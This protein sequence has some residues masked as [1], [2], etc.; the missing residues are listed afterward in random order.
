MV[1]PQHLLYSLKNCTLFSCIFTL[2]VTTSPA[3]DPGEHVRC[4]ASPVSLILCLPVPLFLVSSSEKEPATLLFMADVVLYIN[5]QKSALTLGNAFLSL[6]HLC[7]L[8]AGRLLRCSSSAAGIVQSLHVIDILHKPI[9]P[10][11]S[12]QYRMYACRLGGLGGKSMDISKT[13]K[14]DI[15]TP[16][17]DSWTGSSLCYTVHLLSLHPPPGTPSNR[18]VFR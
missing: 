6:S 10:G 14:P 12:C 11:S 17:S 15:S 5:H 2:F 13:T 1:H 8:D 18:P 3:A 9:Y 16:V 7:K 4:Q